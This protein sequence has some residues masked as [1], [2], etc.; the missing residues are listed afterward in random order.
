MSVH[1]AVVNVF[2]QSITLSRKKIIFYTCGD[3]K[4]Q[5]NA[6]YLM[7]SYAVSGVQTRMLHI[8]CQIIS[9]CN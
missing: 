9:V 4:K 7:G 8:A 6:A 2:A 5:V 3:Q 1:T